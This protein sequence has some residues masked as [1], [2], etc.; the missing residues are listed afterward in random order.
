MIV[1]FG[2]GIL[3][4]LVFGLGLAG[5]ARAADDA[6]ARLAARDD[7]PCWACAVRTEIEA[8]PEVPADA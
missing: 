2:F 6:D 7:A 5:L 8:L 3:L 4:G 1:V